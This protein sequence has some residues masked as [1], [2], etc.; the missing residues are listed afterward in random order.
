MRPYAPRAIAFHGLRE[1]AGYRLK[2]YSVRHGERPLD[3]QQFERGFPLVLAALPS[4]AVTAERP[5]VGLLLA[6]QGRGADYAVLGWWDLE[7]ELPLRVAV[8]LDGETGGW[9]P[10]RNESI[11][12]WDLEILAF[13]RDAYVATLLG[14]GAADDY[15]ARRLAG[16]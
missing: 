1:H 13:E 8:R 5:G 4:P 11:C 14:G 16:A 12:V 7:N 2:L 9:R 6:H 10:A 3:W 15:L